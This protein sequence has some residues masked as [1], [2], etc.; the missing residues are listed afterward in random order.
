M[1]K[2]CFHNKDDYSDWHRRKN[3]EELKR[4][5][6]AYEEDDNERLEKVNSK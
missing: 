3:K 4:E 1:G 2:F 5:L 6:E